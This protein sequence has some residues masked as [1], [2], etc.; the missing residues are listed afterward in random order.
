M[1]VTV[2]AIKITLLVCISVRLPGHTLFSRLPRVFTE[3]PTF[4]VHRPHVT[5]VPF[6]RAEVG[7]LNCE[8]R[9]N[10]APRGAI[11]AR[12]DTS[13]YIFPAEGQVS[14]IAVPVRL[15]CESIENNATR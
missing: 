6:V 13:E 4:F 12:R 1:R 3:A 9:D 2:D 10:Y 15:P 5:P 11:P 14:A 7:R 8:F